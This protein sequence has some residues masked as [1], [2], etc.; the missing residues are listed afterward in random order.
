MSSASPKQKAALFALIVDDHPLLRLAIRQVIEHHFPS[1]V[2]REASTGEEA[3]GIVRTEPVE[4]AVLDVMLPDHS[5]LTVLKRI[6]QLRPQ[7]KCIMLTI[8]DEP[9][10]VRLALSHGASGYLTKETAPDEL[11]DAIRTVLTGARYL[12]KG[13]EGTGASRTRPGSVLSLLPFLSAREME[14][15]S[16]LAKG[17]TASQAAKRLKLSV[18]TVSTYRSRLLEKLQLQTTAELIRYAVDHRL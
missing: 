5:G 2:V 18:K 7:I 12:S 14:V 6:K 17:R 11:R 3:A 4:L 13:L 8:H 15:L 9:Q 1:A 10:Y 16:L